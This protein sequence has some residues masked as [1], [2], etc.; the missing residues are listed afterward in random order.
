MDSSLLDEHPKMIW[1]ELGM[2][3]TNDSVEGSS[4][5]DVHEAQRVLAS[6]TQ[7][8]ARLDKQ[9]GLTHAGHVP[10]KLQAPPEFQTQ[11]RQLW[12]AY[13]KIASALAADDEKAARAGVQALA[14]ALKSVDMK[15]LTDN[16][17][18]MA[19]MQ[20]A[21]ELNSVGRSLQA[22][23]DI[24]GL[25][26]QFAP[27]SGVMQRLAMSFGFGSDQPV[28]R[29]HCPMAFNNKGASWLQQD[30]D[31]RN[32]Y[33]GSTMLKCADQTELIVPGNSSPDTQEK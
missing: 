27:L 26:A 19:W 1:K 7:N 16:Q 21:K 15:L 28:Y 18:H 25:R 11:L 29:L 12:D 4:V 10:D 5:H 33:F 30:D 9:F 20:A 23:E 6:L 17:A 22:A 24:R 13:V 32:P 3:L 14:K 8:L 2:L 31:T